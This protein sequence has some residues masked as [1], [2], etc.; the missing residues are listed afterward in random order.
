MGFWPV[1]VEQAHKARRGKA[2]ASAADDHDP[3]WVKLGLVT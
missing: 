1:S 3:F 2:V